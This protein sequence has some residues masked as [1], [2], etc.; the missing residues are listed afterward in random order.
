[1]AF[2]I[3]LGLE[4]AYEHLQH[5]LVR[6]DWLACDTNVALD[7]PLHLVLQW[8]CQIELVGDSLPFFATGIPLP[9]VN[10]AVN[11]CIGITWKSQNVVPLSLMAAA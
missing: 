7:I 2:T 1:M 3:K 4:S 5:C 9:Q 6:L 8:G 11:S 10:H